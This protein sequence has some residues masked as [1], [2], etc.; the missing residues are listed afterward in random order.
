M[1]GEMERAR[2]ESGRV[3]ATNSAQ[4]GADSFF[5]KREIGELPCLPNRGSFQF[6]ALLGWLTGKTNSPLLLSR[7]SDHRC[8]LDH[9][10]RVLRRL[11]STAASSVVGT[12]CG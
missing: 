9:P 5:G 3:G 2:A 7:F 12:T 10:E 1:R 4:P 11:A 8:A 6:A